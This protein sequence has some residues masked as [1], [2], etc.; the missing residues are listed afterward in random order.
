M[1]DVM[2]AT[3]LRFG[4]KK[5]LLQGMVI[6]TALW[7]TSTMALAEVSSYTMAQFTS[8]PISLIE[9]VVSPQ[10]IINS[11]KDHQLFFKAYNDYS[12][13]DGD[14]EPDTTY[15][16]SID[17]YGYFDTHK[18]YDYDAVDK[19]F[20]PVSVTA[21]KYCTGA[22][23]AYWSG[24]FLN[25]A[26]MTR[27]DAIRKILFGGHRRVDTST[28]TVLE[29][30]YIPP[31]IHAFAKYYD[32]DDVNDLTPFTVNTSEPT[33][34][35]SPPG[36]STSSVAIGTGSKSFNTNQAGNWIKVGDIVRIFSTVNSANYM[37]GTV[38]A[39]D[40]SD[41]NPLTVNVTQTG[42]AGTFAS[43]R[44][45]KTIGTGTI[46]LNTNQ[47]GSW[48][49][50]GDYVSIVDP[51][52]SA[53]YMQGW[54]TVFDSSDGNFMTVNVTK[55]GGSGVPVTWDV[56]NHTR[57]GLTL[58]NVTYSATANIFSQN[59][60]D[61]PLI[62]AAQ[63]NYAFWSAGEVHQCLWEE[64]DAGSNG[65]N[66]NNPY[67]SG[68]YAAQDNPKKT[69]VG[70]G[71]YDYAVR[72]QVCKDA[73][74]DKV[75]DLAAGTEK[76]K[77][78][79]YGNFKPIGLM[80]VYGDDDNLLFG[81]V[82]GTYGKAR[83][84]GEIAQKIAN[85]DEMDGM[86][87]EINLGRDCNG[88]GDVD[89]GTDVGFVNQDDWVDA[90][91]HIGDGTFKR[92]YTSA[93]GPITQ[94][95][96]SQGIIN[97]WSLYRIY[98]YKYG[99]GNWN[100]NTTSSGGDNCPLSINFFGDA[101][102]SQCHDWGNPFA[103]IYLSG[104]RYLAGENAPTDYQSGDG[105]FIEGINYNTG[106]WYDPLTTENYCARLNVVNFNSSVISADT[107]FTTDP[108]QIKD[109]LDTN[110]FGV[111]KDL[112]SA[113]NSRQLTEII[114]RVEG[115]YPDA[116]DPNKKWF[117][118][119]SGGEPGPEVHGENDHQPGRG[120]RPLSGRAGPQRWFPHCRTCLVRTR[121]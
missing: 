78:Y 95:V 56:T 71:I 18:C 35:S 6:G 37:Q 5:H 97:T 86:C 45:I 47:A 38:T 99:S 22:N 65:S 61:P 112:G 109:E 31:D 57:V 106:V 3:L 81:M 104:L 27:I 76:C 119:E 67:Y 91:H 82:A 8:T 52:N 90:T 40:S 54:V 107:V 41:G 98:G 69:D 103:E 70:L 32:G 88:D 7:A 62:R 80:Q 94:A 43:W 83:R 60:T 79:L 63:G 10:V 108:A 15:K 9:S 50:L 33:G 13:L 68:V 110:S 51:A 12:D 21:D 2:I 100:Y 20:E 19:R 48:I 26:S 84:G 49:K 89:G 77:Q 29:R 42:G 1:E 59:V 120:P 93:G 121:Q 46:S 39:F 66:Y 25:W 23:D 72:V 28:D 64:E 30:A 118:G 113:R 92:V 87:R 74:G 114:G 24:N 111:V 73:D 44:I 115:V 116:A 34:T 53:N 16:H 96:K 75:L 102:D 105:Q 58:C 85:A 14:G 4:H 117:V 55:T 11:S 101:S 36:T 17:Y